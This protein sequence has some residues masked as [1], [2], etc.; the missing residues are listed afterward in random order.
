MLCS[1]GV[2]FC[3]IW[4]A[5]FGD[6]EGDMLEGRRTLP[7]IVPKLSRFL[8]AAMLALWS[9]LLTYCCTSFFTRLLAALVSLLGLGLGSRYL[10]Q[11]SSEDDKRSLRYY[12]VGAFLRVSIDIYLVLGLD[13]SRTS[14]HCNE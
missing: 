5:D 7:I 8:M 10:R 4:A 2:I 11:R 9:S 3:T 12:Y 14:P 1:A 13:F 6:E